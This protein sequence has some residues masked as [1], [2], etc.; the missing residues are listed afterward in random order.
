[1]VGFQLLG[2]HEGILEPLFHL[3]LLVAL[4]AKLVLQPRRGFRPLDFARVLF[5]PGL[6]ARSLFVLHFAKHL[7]SA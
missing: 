2:V 6:P 5:R 1:M 4:G 3:A 7:N